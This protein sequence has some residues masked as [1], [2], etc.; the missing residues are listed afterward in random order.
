MQCK[1]LLQQ[2]EARK[3][4]PRVA[5]AGV[6]LRVSRGA[7]VQRRSPSPELPRSEVTS[8]EYQFVFKMHPQA[9]EIKLK[10]K[11]VVDTAAIKLKRRQF[12]E[13]IDRYNHSVRYPIC[14]TG[15]EYFQKELGPILGSTCCTAETCS[16]CGRQI[17]KGVSF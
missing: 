14:P 9:E 17:N 13:I 16:G 3:L 5:R 1:E 6:G 15:T 11:T 12:K 8:Y 4:L 7:R 10:N 2:F